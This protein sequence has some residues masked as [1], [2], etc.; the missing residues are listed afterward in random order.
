MKKDEIVFN[1][2]MLAFFIFF[3]FQALE[4]RFVRRFAEMGSGFWPL[5][6]LSGATV[7]TLLLLISNIRKYLREKKATLGE[8][9]ISAEALTELRGRR[10]KVVLSA[11][12]LLGYIIIMPYVGFV[13]STFL[14]V[15]AFVLAL[16]ERR[17]FV[18]A[19]SPFLVTAL[20]VIIFAKFITMP[21]PRGIDIF[22]S[23]SR[24][25]Y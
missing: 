15:L 12:C 6:M 25:I 18:L 9:P 4:L 17:K 7:L 1:V 21:L 11:L 2:V 13:P 24:L 14:Y 23:F 16:G 5:L 19:I 3:L 10:T 8:Q 22:A 20:T